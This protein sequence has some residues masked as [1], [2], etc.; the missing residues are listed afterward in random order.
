VSGARSGAGQYGFAAIQG[1]E[2]KA[3][4]Q[5]PIPDFPSIE[6]ARSNAYALEDTTDE[7]G[8]AHPR[9]AHEQDLAIHA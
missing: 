2:L 7:C 6:A 8:L 9:L 1:D 4:A 5:P 3:G